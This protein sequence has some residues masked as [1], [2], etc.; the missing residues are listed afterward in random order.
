[1]PGPFPQ[2]G[3]LRGEPSDQRSITN[4]SRKTLDANEDGLILD[5]DGGVPDC[6]RRCKTPATRP[7]QQRTS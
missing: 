5:T 6:G 4:I 1:M 7:V 3:A 2:Q